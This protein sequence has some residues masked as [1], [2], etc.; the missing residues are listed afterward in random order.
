M[1]GKNRL[2]FFRPKVAEV[3]IKRAADIE[4]AAHEVAHSV[5]HRVPE[6]HQA[7]KADKDLAAELRSVSYDQ[8]SVTEGFAE[9]MRLYLTQPETLEPRRPRCTP[10]WSRSPAN[11]ST[12]RRCARLRSA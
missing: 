11:T 5:D 8:K 1:K 7:W 4:V 2:G 10:S 3:R 9:G 6:L 12:A